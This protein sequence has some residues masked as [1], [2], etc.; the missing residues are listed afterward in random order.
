MDHQDWQEIVF[1]KKTNAAAVKRDKNSSCIGKASE[2]IST[3]S[4]KPAWVI[5][6]D[7][8]AVDT[9][10]PLAFVSK[11]AAQRII[12]GRIAKKL[13]QKDLARHMNMQPKEIQEIE[14]GKAVEN[15]QVISRI[16]RFLGV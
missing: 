4:S 10:K 16:K 12:V 2:T 9:G 14:S 15:K 5:E 13:C 11:D 6:R 7:V 8:D 1:K 3:L